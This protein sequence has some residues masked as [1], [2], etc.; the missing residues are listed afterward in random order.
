MGSIIVGICI[1]FSMAFIGLWLKKRMLNKYRFFSAYADYLRYASEKIGYERMPVSELNRTFRSECSEFVELLLKKQE[2]S[3]GLSAAE[4]SSVKD[5]LDSI[6]RSD[7]D[8]QVGSLQ[9]KY[10]E[11]KGFLDKEGAK[12]KKD[13][14]LYFKLMVLAGIALFIILV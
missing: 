10:S 5:Y 2:P 12:W 1:F 3:I 9:A 6:G 14:S 8:T 7:A 13:A 11:I 4:I